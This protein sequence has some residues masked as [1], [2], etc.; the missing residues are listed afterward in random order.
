MNNQQDR[1][2]SKADP[3]VSVCIQTYQHAPYIGQ[4]LDG[5]L[6]Q[7]TTFPFEI[8]VGE[9]DSTDEEAEQASPHRGCGCTRRRCLHQRYSTPSR[10]SY[11]F[12]AFGN[13][14]RRTAFALQL[15]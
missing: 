4:C 9:D 12:E 11:L 2:Q 15:M 10:T 8:I 7:V 14:A 1:Q 3:V 6:M 5:I 13:A